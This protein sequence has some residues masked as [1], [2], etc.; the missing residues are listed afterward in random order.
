MDIRSGGVLLN[1]SMT[2]S[3]HL[4]SCSLGS[5][6][7]SPSLLTTGGRELSGCL[8]RESTEGTVQLSG[9]SSFNSSFSIVGDFVISRVFIAS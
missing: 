8:A 6:S 5:L 2:C 9:V 4:Y 1:C 7:W 3:F